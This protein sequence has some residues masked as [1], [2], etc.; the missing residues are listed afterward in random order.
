MSFGEWEVDELGNLVEETAIGLVR[1]KKQQGEDFQFPYIK[2]NNIGNDNEFDAASTVNVDAS[3][4]EVQKYKLEEGDLL[5]NTRNSHE[6]VGKSCLY[7]CIG[8]DHVLFN[9]NIMRIRFGNRVDATFA[10]YAF[11]SAPVVSQLKA[12]VS[13][14]TNVAGIYYKSLKDLKLPVPP[15]AEQKRIVSILDEAFSAIAKAKE[16]AEKNLANARELFESYLNRVF[17]QQGPGWQEGELSELTTKIGSGA[18]PKGG[19]KS[20]KTEGISL[21]RSLNVH[22][23]EFRVKN[24]AFIDQ[25]QA[26]KLDNVILEPS[27]VLLNITGASVAR[28]C[29]LPDD[30]LPA[31]VNQHVSIVRPIAE[32]LHPEFVC[33]MLT[34]KEYKDRLLA[35]G[36]KGGATRQ[37]I[38]KSQIQDFTINF[39]PTL[40]EQSGICNRLAGLESETMRLETIYTQKL[41]NLDELK[42]SLL[43]KAFTGQLTQNDA[44]EE[45]AIG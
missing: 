30:I 17:T 41:A 40:E 28:C 1:N 2:M 10:A 23:R 39:P 22:D 19:K 44:R 42:Q 33:Y 14:T 12:M 43:Q 20:Y 37:A 35:T 16:N 34:S 6:L 36:E 7:T 3:P 4:E 27:D 15:K 25:S 26:D 5:F 11:N 8:H 24:L 45:V 21:V 29:V 9:N 32:R 31:R 13:G 18:T 38:T